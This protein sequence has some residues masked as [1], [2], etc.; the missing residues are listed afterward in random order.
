MKQSAIEDSQEVGGNYSLR[1]LIL[2]AGGELGATQSSPAPRSLLEDPFGGR[3]LDWI[4]TSYK[5]AHIEDITFVGGYRIEEIGHSY[6][7][8][9]FIYNPDWNDGGVLSSLYHARATIE[10]GVL[11]SYGDVVYRE[12]VCRQL[13]EGAS[14]GMAVAV[15]MSFHHADES[16]GEIRKN[17]AII[18]EGRLEDIGFLAVSEK[19]NAEFVGLVY[20]APDVTPFI[21]EFLEEQYPTLI[22]KPFEQAH[23]IRLAYM[24]DLIRYVQHS[25]LDVQAVDIGSNWAEMDE[26]GSLARFVMGTKSET[27][28]RLAGMIK[29]GRFCEQLVFCVGDWKEARGRLTQAICEQFSPHPIVVRSSAL[30]E[31]SWQESMAG[32][33]QSVLNVDSQNPD[34]IADAMDAVVKSYGKSAEAV[35]DDNQILIQRMVQNVVM[36]GVVFTREIQ[37]NAPYYVINYDDESHETD[38]VTSGA[39]DALKTVIVSR[40]YEGPMPSPRLA[41]L[42]DVVQE[43]ESITG[44]SILDIEFAVDEGED[45]Y[46]LQVRPLTAVDALDAASDA[47]VAAAV[48]REQSFFSRLAA[49]SPY[50]FGRTTFLGD[51][52]DWNPA[53]MIGPRPRPLAF[54]LY[55]HLITDKAWRIARGQ[56]GYNNPAG[57]R[58]MLN[59]AGHPYIDVRAS[60]NNLIP[61]NLP[62]PLAEKVIDIYLNRLQAHPDRHDKVEFEVCVTCLDFAFDSNAEELTH[63]GLS[64]SEV[65]SFRDALRTLTDRIVCEKDRPMSS[66]ISELEMLE[67]RRKCF[68]AQSTSGE[69]VPR[70]IDCLLDDCI[71]CGVIPFSILARYAFVANSLLKSLVTRGALSQEALEEFLNQIETVATELVRDMDA[72]A[73]NRLSQDLFLS[74][75]GHLRPGTYDI[76]SLRYD[77]APDVYFALER[78]PPVSDDI[79]TP[80]RAATWSPEVLGNVQSLIDEANFSFQ[81]SHLFD[82]CRRAISLREY[83]KFEFTKTVSEVLRLVGMMGEREGFSREELSFLD[84]QDLLTM[85]VNRPSGSIREWLG[86]SM[87]HNRKW[88]SRSERIHLPHLILKPADFNVMSLE[89]SRPNFVTS[90]KVSGSVTEVLPASGSYNLQGKI[91]LIESADPGYDWIFS[92]Q[93]AGLITRYGGAASHM[94]IRASEFNVPAAIGCGEVLYQRVRRAQFVELDC[95]GKHVRTS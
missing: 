95:M 46:V 71:S 28:A 58:L 14:Q 72:V 80:E 49:P 30:A 93:I 22:G 24:T 87:A 27:L 35:S 32:A 83:G 38:T 92:H 1:G 11:I 16:E 19:T 51:M 40:T 74:R 20:L 5:R 47:E 75:Y 85:G 79:P 8:L 81:A 56:I 3:V 68:L 63:E 64:S 42:R 7:A 17:L 73:T 34:A 37:H 31:D 2:G 18:R 88:S 70:L 10:G 26:P 48:E 61:A 55:Q 50:L 91:V 15:D 86:D 94:T 9:N 44:C 59:V 21:R 52:P 77:E 45:I 29:K 41:A 60:F 89:V 23:D 33:F 69:D 13:I 43:L 66:L 57:A 12:Q 25:G 53:E 54:S 67:Q 36:H 84:I 76:T 4:L 65:R 62:A 82:F 90:Q 78:T 39:G 6:P